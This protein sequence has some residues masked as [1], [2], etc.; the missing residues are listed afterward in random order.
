MPKQEAQE[1]SGTAGVLVEPKG[2]VQ[3]T[4]GQEF[5]QKLEWEPDH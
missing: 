1:G 2:R 4:G 3:V 5:T